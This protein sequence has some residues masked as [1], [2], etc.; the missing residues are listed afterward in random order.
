MTINPTQHPGAGQCEIT[1]V[2]PGPVTI[3]LVEDEQSV[4]TLARLILEGSGYTVLEAANGIEL[5]RLANH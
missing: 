5:S 1:P 2:V 4:R 3:L